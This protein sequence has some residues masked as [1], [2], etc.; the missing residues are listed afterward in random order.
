MKELDII[1][2][3]SI[4]FILSLIYG[5]ERQLTHKPVSFG[6]FIF[7]SAGACGL[8]IIAITINLDNPTPI[9]AEI[10]TGIGF[11]GAGA[12][13]KT[14]DRIFGFTTAASI[15]IFSILGMAIGLG[16]FVSALIIYLII[17]IVNFTDRILQKYNIGYYQK[18]ITIIFSKNISKSD[19]K[20]LIGA[21]K[22]KTLSLSFNEEK[23]E[24]QITLLFKSK[25]R[26]IDE[27][28]EI[29]FNKKDIKG[30]TLE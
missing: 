26:T 10:I 16:Y 7:V 14:S 27:L 9:L 19:I 25:K 11:L 22:Y 8:A 15:W 28:P 3:F 12:L 5:I 18:K 29:L 6:T 4:I 17:W 13:I 2:R 30:F 20:S 1:I 24:F 21:K 23:N